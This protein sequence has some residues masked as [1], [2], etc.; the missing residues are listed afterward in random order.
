MARN[1]EKAGHFFARWAKAQK[2][3]NAFTSSGGVGG[4]GEAR[5]PYL[6][7]EC[8]VLEECEKWRRSVVTEILRKITAL[9]NESLGEARLRELNDEANKLIRTKGHWERR[10]REL[11]GD[12]RNYEK[13]HYEVDGVEL[14]NERGGYKY[15][16]CAKNLPGI[17]DIFEQSREM[18]AAE[19]KNRRRKRSE[20]ARH[21][22]PEY[23]GVGYGAGA[24]AGAGAGEEESAHK[25]TKSSSS[26]RP[27]PP[28]AITD[29]HLVSAEAQREEQLV[30]EAV[31]EFQER[32]MKLLVDLKKDGMGNVKI[33]KDMLATMLD[34][35]AEEAAADVL[36]MAQEMW[37]L[38]QQQ[39]RQQQQKEQQQ[40]AVLAESTTAGAGAGAGAVD[41]LIEAKKQ[42]LLSRF[43]L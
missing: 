34:D 8:H 6:A 35:S 38:Q 14:P 9:E 21:I 11:G 16:G 42:T 10:I 28:A 18:R 2:N 22:T 30:A 1:S 40:Q 29:T 33:A 5:R 12:T 26:S 41:L 15:Y 7:S 25:H 19:E 24:R 27:A 3:E 20:V 17:Q 23:Y 37:N 39:Q 13:H 36:K 43:G 31:H 32:K 4:D